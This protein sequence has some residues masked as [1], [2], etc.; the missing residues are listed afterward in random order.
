VWPS[1]VAL[2]E[3]TR[4]S[5]REEPSAWATSRRSAYSSP[6]RLQQ[7]RTSISRCTGLHEHF[8][9]E[10][11]S[12]AVATSS[13]EYCDVLVDGES[14]QEQTVI[15]MSSVAQCFVGYVQRFFGGI[16]HHFCRRQ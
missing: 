3:S 1:A 2:S 5:D 11:T 10:Q 12:P 9:C 6:D 14:Q 16:E 4:T 15:L 13:R 7:M 8:V